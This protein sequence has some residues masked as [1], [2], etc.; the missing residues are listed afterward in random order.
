VNFKADFADEDITAVLFSRIQ[1]DLIIHTAGISRTYECEK[2]KEYCYRINVEATNNLINHNPNSKIIFFS[3]YAVYNTPIGNC[4]E[5]CETSSINYYIGTKIKAEN[6]F[7][8]HKNSVILRP[9]VMYGF[10][11]QEQ[12]SNNYFMQLIKNIKSKS[13]T[14]SPI[15][16][17]FNPIWVNVVIN[18][19]NELIN[20]EITGIFNLG[21]NEQISKYD[22]NKY[23]IQKLK[24]DLKYL[25]PIK[26][27]DLNI[28]RPKAGTIS[29]KKIQETLNFSLPT[30]ECMMNDFIVSASED[31]TRYLNSNEL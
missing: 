30:L 21:S 1:P 12:P 20:S 22:F 23:L 5:N 8:R 28:E 31:V 2:N 4:D 19:L 11:K 13:I 26:S 6:L 10:V 14:E 16:H 18:A 7:F 15:D 25:K 29:S 27:T 17:F 3:T 24:L 9:S